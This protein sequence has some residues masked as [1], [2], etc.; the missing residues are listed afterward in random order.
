VSPFS[1]RGGVL[2]IRADSMAI[3]ELVSFC[4]GDARL[5]GVVGVV[6]ALS[7]R[8]RKLS[9]EPEDHRRRVAHSLITTGGRLVLGTRPSG[10]IWQYSFN[11]SRSTLMKPL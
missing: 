2:E 6:L 10:H 3:A 5:V 8:R 7:L 9:F 11:D 1:V 4:C